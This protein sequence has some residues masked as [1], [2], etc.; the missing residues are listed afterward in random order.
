MC[1]SAL[2]L[3]GIGL[4]VFGCGNERFGGCGSVHS[5]HGSPA[6]SEQAMTGDASEAQYRKGS[7]TSTIPAAFT[8]VAVGAHSSGSG[9]ASSA[10][11]TAR[12]ALPMPSR[13]AVVASRRRVETILCT[14]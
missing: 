12:P 6:L 1:A 14:Q 11:S 2:R 3:V 8:N 7:A 9:L 13:C 4:V 10:S 5:L